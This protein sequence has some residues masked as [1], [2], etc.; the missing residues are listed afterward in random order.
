[1]GLGLGLE[2]GV[3]VGV[4]GGQIGTTAATVAKGKSMR[5]GI[6][7]KRAQASCTIAMAMRSCLRHA[8]TRT[9][10]TRVST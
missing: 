9:V 6:V 5:E 7:R 10:V 4:G 8:K 1:M 3:G 2:L